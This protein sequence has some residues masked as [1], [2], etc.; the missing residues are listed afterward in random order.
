MT[1]GIRL[2]KKICELCNIKPKV[3]YDYEYNEILIYPD[4]YDEENFVKL[5]EIKPF[6]SKYEGNKVVKNL[7][8]LNVLYSFDPISNR[9]ECLKS[10]ISLIM[11]NYPSITISRQPNERL[12]VE[13]GTI[14]MRNAIK[15]VKWLKEK[16]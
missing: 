7:T 5:M 14:R 3:V 11:W 8:I 10:L 2:S 16:D 13:E 9:N 4:F 1:K 12:I 6:N 15:R